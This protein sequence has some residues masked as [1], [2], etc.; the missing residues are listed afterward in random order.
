MVPVVAVVPESAM[1]ILKPIVDEI[2]E[3]LDRAWTTAPNNGHAINMR[4]NGWT[5]EMIA[6]GQI[7][8]AASEV[9]LEIVVKS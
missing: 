3:R 2:V 4:L 1:E 5:T 9:E 6:W 7:L 8:T